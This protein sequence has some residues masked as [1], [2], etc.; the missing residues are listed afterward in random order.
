[1]TDFILDLATL[2]PTL[3]RLE[4][5]APAQEVGLP[6]SDWPGG[7]RAELR[8]EKSGSRVS[9]RGTVSSTAH[10]TCVRCLH[11]FERGVTADLTVFAEQSGSS[12]NRAEEDLLERDHYMLF[13]DGRRL[14]LCE[15]VREAL[16]LELPITPRCREDCLGL[17]PKCGAELNL[18]P[19]ACT[20]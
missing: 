6:D 1:M 11:D 4:V 9:V 3:N 2:K 14:D 19:C 13:H 7:V 17:C 12:R 5:E 8:V 10:L 16:L 20:V 15:S 18:G